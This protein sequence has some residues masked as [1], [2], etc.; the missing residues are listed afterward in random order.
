MADSIK[1]NME[2]WPGRGAQ[3]LRMGTQFQGNVTAT[4]NKISTNLVG[5]AKG[6][7]PWGT[8]NRGRHFADSW[9]ARVQPAYAGGATITLT[10]FAPHAAY[11]LFP[12][13]PHRIPLAGNAHLHWTGGKFGP[14]DHFAAH[15]N[16]PG[17]KGNPVHERALAAE[18][19]D[20]TAQMANLGQE[21]TVE[22][23]N[24]FKT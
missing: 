20:I 8:Q 23:A 21:F 3:L 15:V 7:S 5:T 11:V 12:T 16:H 22:L 1:V 19:P 10:N 13:R 14:G 18:Q 24:V 9:T 4:A 6:I 17:T 2:G